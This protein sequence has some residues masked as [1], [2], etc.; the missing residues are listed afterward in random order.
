MPLPAHLTCWS[1]TL[2]LSRRSVASDPC[3]RRWR[4]VR[5]ACST[6]CSP[7]L[8]AC[9]CRMT[10]ATAAAKQ[11]SRTSYR[12]ARWRGDVVPVQGGACSLHAARVW[13]FGG[14]VP[15]TIS[16]RSPPP[17][18][19]CRSGACGA[20]APSLFSPPRIDCYPPTPVLL[21]CS[22]AGACAAAAC[23]GGGAGSVRARH[24]VWRQQHLQ[25]ARRAGSGA[26]T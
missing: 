10:V 8:S 4:A 24:V 5:W 21:P 11:R 25:A 12:C 20:A 1:A 13:R 6:W 2:E 18:L 26:C 14:D 16:P 15:P 22:A 3:R 19:P 17:A 9:S 23:G 7:I